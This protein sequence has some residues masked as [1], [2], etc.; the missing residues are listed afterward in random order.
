MV[1]GAKLKKFSFYAK[2]QQPPTKKFEVVKIESDLNMVLKTPFYLKE[3]SNEVTKSDYPSKH[4]IM[5]GSMISFM[6]YS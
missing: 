2:M 3:K 1:Y 5:T 4:K 6:D